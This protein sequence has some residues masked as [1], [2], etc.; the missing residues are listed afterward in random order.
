MDPAQIMDYIG[1]Y[2]PLITFTYTI[3]HLW[4]LKPFLY[5]FF[6]S[7]FIN[8]YVN[9]FLKNIIREPR[10]KNP[11]PFVES[12]VNKSFGMPS[13]HSQTTFYSTAFLYLVKHDVFAT[14]ISASISIITIYQ[15]LKYRKHTEQ[16]VGVGMILGCTFAWIVYMATVQML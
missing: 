16:Q 5:V 6:A 2:G 10:P 8:L 3:Y 9:I 1:L 14:I 13:T 7:S 4:T 11:I 15:R 12:S